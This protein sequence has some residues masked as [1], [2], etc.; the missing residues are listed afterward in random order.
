MARY[1]RPS[2]RSAGSLLAILVVLGSLLVPVPAAAG[3]VCDSDMCFYVPPPPSGPGCQSC[4]PPGN[5]TTLIQGLV[6]DV[7][8]STEP[9]RHQF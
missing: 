3:K 5:P 8:G 2:G 9:L 6:T 1:R 4:V 7:Y